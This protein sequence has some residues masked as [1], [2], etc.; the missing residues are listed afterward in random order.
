VQWGKK[1][2]TFSVILSVEKKIGGGEQMKKKFLVTVIALLVC[3]MM[4]TPFA[5]AKPGAEKNNEDKF[6][7]FELI[8]YSL[9][10]YTN[11]RVWDTPPE[12]AEPKTSH[13]RGSE[14]TNALF[15]TVLI[16][17]APVPLEL[18][19]S[20]VA[21]SNDNIEKVFVVKVKETITF[22]DDEEKIGTLEISVIDKWMGGVFLDAAGTFTGHGTDAFEGVKVRGITY[23]SGGLVRDGTVTNWPDLS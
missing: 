15:I 19:Y 1:I 20:A 16:D 10:D 3:S 12:P 14:F 4:L 21:N 13:V 18:T 11:A 22:W 9:P 2:N 6:Q 17:G 7:S 8:F 23:I 5:M